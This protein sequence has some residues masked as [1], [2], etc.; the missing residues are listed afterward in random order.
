MANYR[1]MFMPGG[2]WFFTVCLLDRRS[3]LL[4]DE[5]ALL[6]RAFHDARQGLP[7]R[8]DAVVVL[9]EHLHAIW[10]LPPDDGKGWLGVQYRFLVAV[11]Q[12]PEHGEL[13]MAQIGVDEETAELLSLPLEVTKNRDEWLA[14]S[15]ETHIG[16]W[17]D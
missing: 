6:R 15:R 3:A 14:I 9:P 1:R 12:A 13:S 7:F 4:V 10:T 8:F 5:I 17:L 11:L 2:C 16:A